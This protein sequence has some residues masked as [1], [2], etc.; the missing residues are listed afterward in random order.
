MII[1]EPTSTPKSLCKYRDGFVFQLISLVFLVYFLNPSI[2]LAAD[3]TL[4]WD[5][6]SGVVDGY[7]VFERQDGE[8]YDYENPSWE[9]SGTTSTVYNLDEGVTHYFVVRAFNEFGESAD[10]NEVGITFPAY[11]ADQTSI[12]DSGEGSGGGSGLS[13]FISTLGFGQ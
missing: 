10:S 5:P 13:C 7:R 3:V 11:I 8:N 6:S 12:V 4:T 2:T 1:F 9:G